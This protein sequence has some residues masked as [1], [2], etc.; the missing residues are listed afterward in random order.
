MALRVRIRSERIP[1]PVNQNLLLAILIAAL[2]AL[3]AQ[4]AVML[5][6]A[7]IGS[8]A[9]SLAPG[10]SLTVQATVGSSAEKIAG[11]DYFL[12]GPV[13]IVSRDITGSVFTDLLTTDPT[14]PGI[15]L[16]AVVTD[17]SIPA[18]PGFFSLGTLTLQIP[19]GTAPGQYVVAINGGVDYG[20]V[21]DSF[22]DHPFDAGGSFPLTVTAVS[23]PEP[24]MYAVGLFAVWGMLIL[25]KVK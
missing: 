6:L 22:I 12:T 13:K 7:P 16:G 20:W 21:N 14:P 24:S 1:I 25:R 11:L 2:A 10:Q 3:P 9:P 17:P 23:T 18:G 8:P 4:S 5:Y 19:D 15:D